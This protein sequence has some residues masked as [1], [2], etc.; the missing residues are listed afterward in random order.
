ME[1]SVLRALAL[2]EWNMPCSSAPTKAAEIA[3]A[4]RRGAVGAL[5]AWNDREPCGAQHLFVLVLG[6]T[7]GVRIVGVQEQVAV[8]QLTACAQ[9]SA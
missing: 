4:G 1:K 5:A 2:G 6:E 8:D 7:A 9:Q 3:E